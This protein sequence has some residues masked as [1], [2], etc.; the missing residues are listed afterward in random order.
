MVSN[1]AESV[2][3]ADVE[4]LF[5]ELGKLEAAFLAFDANGKST[6]VAHVTYA[7]ARNATQAYN[8]YNGVAL[9]GQ[10][11]LIEYVGAVKRLSVHSRLA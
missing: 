4:D 9:D 3:Q 8:R 11:M 6:G 1:L 7:N 5:G 2:S 10:N